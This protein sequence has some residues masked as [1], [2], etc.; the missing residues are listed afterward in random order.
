MRRLDALTIILSVFIAGGFGYVALQWMGL[1]AITAGIWTQA[2]LVMGLV[3]WLL[4]YG[5]RAKNHKMTYHQQ[6]KDYEEAVID[7]RI[8]EMSSEELAQLQADLEAEKA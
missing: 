7:K 6:L 4:S 2:L 1:D 5:L 3:G 8:S